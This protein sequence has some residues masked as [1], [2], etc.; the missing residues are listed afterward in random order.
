MGRLQ[1]GPD[2]R[3]DT[4]RSRRLQR[5]ALVDE[6]LEVGALDPAHH[7]VEG[8]V[9]LA[10]PVH[11]DDIGMVYGGGEPGLALEPGLEHGVGG[12]LGRDDLQRNRP[13]E[14][15]LRRAVND[16][17]AAAAGHPL[18][19]ATGEPRLQGQVRHVEECDGPARGAIA[20]GARPTPAAAT[21]PGP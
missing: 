19:A 5:A 16:A 13:A 20:T 4:R 1:A 3:H 11:R 18:D 2:L 14:G 21:I 9:L 10:R 8:A 6:R 12:P 7:E 17:H 15:Q